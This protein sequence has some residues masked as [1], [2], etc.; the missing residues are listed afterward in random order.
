MIFTIKS[1]CALEQLDCAAS[2]SL[3]LQ[4]LRK[5]DN[6]LTIYEPVGHKYLLSFLYFAKNIATLLQSKKALTKQT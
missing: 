2:A 3:K 1:C 6:P 5:L 4:P